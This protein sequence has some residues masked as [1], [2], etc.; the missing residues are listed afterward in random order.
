M[1]K[2]Q[3]Q[4]NK[5]KKITSTNGAGTSTQPH[6]KGKKK[7]KEK[8]ESRHRPSQYLSRKTNSKC[9]TDRN[10]KRGIVKFLEDHVGANR[11]QV[12]SG[13]DFVDP[14]PEVQST[15][16]RIDM[17]DCIE[18]KDYCTS[19]GRAGGERIPSRFCAVTTGPD[20]ELKP[21][22]VRS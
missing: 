15:K 16:E 9:I 6:A 4:D 11:D 17:L 20:A 3:R 13:N 19:G 12:A 7:E 10:V 5:A 22:T 18:I 8:K 1:A 14:T 21:R 2:E